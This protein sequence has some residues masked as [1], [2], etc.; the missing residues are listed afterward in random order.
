M[1]MYFYIFPLFLGST[2]I[3]WVR[4]FSLNTIEM[5]EFPSQGIKNALVVSWVYMCP[6]S[7]FKVLTMYLVYKALMMVYKA[8]IG[9]FWYFLYFGILL[10]K[11]AATSERLANVML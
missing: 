3:Q 9:P 7:A 6:Y 4:K 5:V 10:T 1:K 2:T 8:L 11:M